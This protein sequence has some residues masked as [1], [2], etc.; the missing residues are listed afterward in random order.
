MKS[1][2][3]NNMKRLLVTG[4]SGFLGW[5]ICSVANK[6]WN[7]YGVAFSNPIEISGTNIKVVDLTDYYNLKQLFIDVAPDA[8]IHA[9]AAANANFCQLNQT[10]S[11]K[12]N[13]DTSIN[14]AGLCMEQNVP[15]VFVSTDMVFDGLNAPYKEEAP[16]CPINVYGEQKVLAEKEIVRRCQEVAVC[17]TSIMFGN[18]PNRAKSWF[19]KNLEAVRTQQNLQ[20]FVDEFR[21]F[22][23]VRKAVSGLLL[24]LGNING[25]LH[26]SGDERISR[27]DFARLMTMA[28]HINNARLTPCN[29]KDVQVIAPR[30]NDLSLDNSK[31]K[32]LGFNPSS[33]KKELELLSDIM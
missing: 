2:D 9:A 24:S 19:Q 5:N 8:V 32:A 28:F 20:L 4:A 23:S 16:V 13:V 1:I 17:R 21:T 31:A 11:H 7:V 10:E 12:I 15:L 26:L 33:I 6:S 3:D 18:H 25:I 22:L 27:Y 14:I 30:A 29:L